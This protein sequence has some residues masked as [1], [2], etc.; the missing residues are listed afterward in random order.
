MNLLLKSEFLY[1]I[2]DLSVNSIL[3]MSCNVLM[4]FK[5]YLNTAR[6]KVKAEILAVLEKV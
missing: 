6:M 1:N 5:A 4:Y 2:K 3:S